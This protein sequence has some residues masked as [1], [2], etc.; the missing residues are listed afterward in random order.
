MPFAPFFEEKRGVLLLARR[1][2]KLFSFSL[3]ITLFAIALF[4]D[5]FTGLLGC[6]S[7]KTSSL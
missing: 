1:T 5:T 6:S 4:Q 3:S 7:P 2:Q